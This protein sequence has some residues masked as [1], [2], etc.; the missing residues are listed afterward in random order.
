MMKTKQWRDLGR[1]EA[2]LIG[3]QY[4]GNDRG[5]GS[6][7]VAWSGRRGGLAGSS[8]ARPTPGS[9]FGEGWGIEIDQTSQ[10]SPQNVQVLAEIPNL[11][12]PASPRR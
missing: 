10:D 12:G 1:P 8:L 4:R 5:R 6:V 2:A 9:Q 7:A 3:V 11:S